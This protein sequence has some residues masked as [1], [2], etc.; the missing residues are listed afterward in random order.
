MVEPAAPAQRVRAPNSAPVEKEEPFHGT[1][2]DELT[3][4]RPPLASGL[5]NE[6][7]PEY[8]I[9]ASQLPPEADVGIDK[10]ID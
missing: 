6:L 2:L 1:I 5:I 7:I 8:M 3:V 4:S 9:D 10:V